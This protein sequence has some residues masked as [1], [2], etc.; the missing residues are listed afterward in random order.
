MTSRGG[1]C[2]PRS[3]WP[4]ESNRRR[5]LFGRSPKKRSRF[6]ARRPGFSRLVAWVI[7]Q[8]G[9]LAELKSDPMLV[10]LKSEFAAMGLS[11]PEI[12]AGVVLTMLVGNAYFQAG[13]N[14]AIGGDPSDER[15]S[16]ALGQTILDYV[17]STR[18]QSSDPGQILQAIENSPRP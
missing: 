18:S 13:I 5:S 14:S 2:W 10:R 17:A 1:W 15:L 9:D 7:L 11:D 6:L 4:S 8:V 12:H 3:D 16:K